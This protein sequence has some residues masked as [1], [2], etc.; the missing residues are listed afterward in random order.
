MYIT[1]PGPAT[2]GGQ[3]ALVDADDDDVIS[4]RQLATKV[5]VFAGKL[6]AAIS[7]K[8]SGMS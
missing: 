8:I 7:I 2:D 1:R 6:T 3:A 5:L 4:A